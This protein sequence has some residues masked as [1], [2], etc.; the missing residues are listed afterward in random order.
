MSG[1]AVGLLIIVAGFLQI[2]AAS[3]AIHPSTASRAL[4]GLGLPGR[5]AHFIVP[6]GVAAEET[7]AAAI[8]LWPRAPGAQMAC[9]ALFGAFALVA[10]FALRRG[11]A[12]ECGCFGAL[13][14]SKLG[15]AQVVQFTLVVPSIILVSLF[16]PDWSTQTGLGVLFVV[17]VA[18]GAALLSFL[19]PVWWRIRRDR[20]S[21]GS[22]Q[23]HLRQAGSPEMQASVGQAGGAEMQTSVN[24]AGAR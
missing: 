18:A 3:K 22:V 6:A 1:V 20:R 16:A 2:S 21:L 13:H 10:A 23:A 9:V 8:L 17:H 11:D 14:R 12:V 7:V 4:L 15:W 19:S 5:V 24:E